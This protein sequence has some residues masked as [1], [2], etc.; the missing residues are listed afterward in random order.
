[1]MKAGRELDALVAEKVMGYRQ[2]EDGSWF[3]PGI[4]TGFGLW[5][6]PEYSTSIADAWLVVE[7]LKLFKGFCLRQRNDG[8]W[9]S[10]RYGKWADGFDD[11][12]VVGKTTAPHAICLAALKAVGYNE[13]D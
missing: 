9:D 8:M 12:I 10:V 6:L 2:A 4:S 7:K 5:E 11:Q 3:L 1:M 13:S